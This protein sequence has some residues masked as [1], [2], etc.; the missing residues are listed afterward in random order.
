[1]SQAEVLK[2]PFT[3]EELEKWKALL[4]EKRD[5]I[6]G[7]IHDLI[8]DAMD[9]EDGHIAPT[10]QADRGS[11]VDIQEMSL[12]MVGNEEEILWQIDRA[13]AKIKTGQ[14]IPFG[15]CEHLKRPIQKSRLSLLPW[16][17]LSIEGANYM[18]ENGMTLHDMIIAD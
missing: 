10:H 17:P 16:T 4:K 2:T 6:R 13:L 1:M 7:D 18:D 15:L 12:E 5:M 8:K 9:S 3:D 14:P 11:D